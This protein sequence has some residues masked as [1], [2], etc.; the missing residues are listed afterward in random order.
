M[1][2]TLHLTLEK[3]WFDLIEL[4]EKNK[5]YREFKPYWCCRLLLY[6]G[7]KRSQKWWEQ[8][9]KKNS[10]MAD[11]VVVVQFDVL[12]MKNGYGKDDPTLRVDCLGLSYGYRLFFKGAT[13]CKERV[14][15]FELGKRERII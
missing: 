13:P 8:S 6:D 14:F 10:I 2:N 15:C 3:K 5:E 11:L 7:K 12:I 4:F 9:I 1:S